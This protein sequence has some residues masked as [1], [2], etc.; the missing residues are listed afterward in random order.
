MNIRKKTQRE[1]KSQKKCTI[2]LIDGKKMNK[3][4][5]KRPKGRRKKLKNKLYDK[6][7]KWKFRIL[8]WRS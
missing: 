2:R 6:K 1:D 8:P 3:A 5:R 4:I 7:Y